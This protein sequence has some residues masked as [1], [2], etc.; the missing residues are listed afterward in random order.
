MP[1][2]G[3]CRLGE[4]HEAVREK[5]ESEFASLVSARGQGQAEAAPVPAEAALGVP[6]PIV[7]SVREPRCIAR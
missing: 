3:L 6:A 7:E 2:K 1:V 4:K 5:A